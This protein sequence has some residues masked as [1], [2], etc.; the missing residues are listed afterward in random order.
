[1]WNILAPNGAIQG[2]LDP[3]ALLAPREVMKLKADEVIAR[4]SNRNGHIFNLGHGILP[5]TDV[6]DVAALVDHVHQVSS[7]TSR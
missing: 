4:A 1:M 7:L 2:N 6:D 5:Q 3:L